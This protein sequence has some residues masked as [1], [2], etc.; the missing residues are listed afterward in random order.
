MSI[1]T[2]SH[3]RGTI[4][5]PGDRRHYR[6]AELAVESNEHGHANLNALHNTLHHSPLYRYRRYDH[7]GP[8]A[9]ALGW[10]TNARTKL[11]MIDD[12][13][14]AIAEGHLPIHSEGLVDECLAFG[15]TDTGER[16]AQPGKHD[17]LVIAAAIAWQVRK[18]PTPKAGIVA[19]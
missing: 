11:L 17:D 16:G 9:E 14:E 7:S 12:L 2:A 3:G 8:A 18:R 4:P 19:L 1:V 6:D 13:A 15:T 10:P 5:F